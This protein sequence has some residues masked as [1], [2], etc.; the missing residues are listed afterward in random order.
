MATSVETLK[1]VVSSAF[2]DTAYPGDDRVAGCSCDE[3]EGIRMDFRGQTTANL[4]AETLEENY[5]ALPLFLP[6]AFHYFIPAYMLYAAEHIGS[7]VERFT[8][9]S[10][11][12]SDFDEFCLERFRQ[13]TPAQNEAVIRFLEFL[14]EQEIEGDEQDKRE[15]D[16]E[17]DVGIRI[18]KAIGQDPHAPLAK[19]HDLFHA[20]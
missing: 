3:C 10:L 2:A 15:Y 9:Y 14:K 11:V 16:E 7:V 18:W 17:I 1:L 6:E 4:P 20:Q 13:F 12:P 5:S 8:K 19:I